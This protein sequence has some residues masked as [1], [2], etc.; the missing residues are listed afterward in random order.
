MTDP[1]ERWHA[2][3]DAVGAVQG[4]R[5]GVFADLVER[6]GAAGRFHHDF[7]HAS[8]VVDTVLSIQQQGDA[9]APVV[10]A[11]WFHDAVYDP[12]A[13]KGG[14]E[15]LSAVL[16]TTALTSLGATL[17]QVGEVARLIC[18]TV[19]HTP[20]PKDRAG[21]LLCDADLCV[22]ASPEAEYD[23]Y[24]R[25]VRAEYRH[26]SDDDWRTGRAAVLRSF[27]DRPAIFHTEFGRRWWE[28]Q[29]RSNIS[30]EIESL[31]R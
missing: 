11:A 21:A 19:D 7:A 5:D 16:A 27:L 25:G 1:D 3:L 15:G 14:N 29:A 2:A 24:V 4:D 22:L 13:A 17:S 9:W 30:R 26:V 23:C 18:L 28:P 20:G 6:H 10:L 12:T 8:S 31:R